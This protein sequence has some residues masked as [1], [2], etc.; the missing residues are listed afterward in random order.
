LTYELNESAAVRSNFSRDGA[1]AALVDLIATA[2]RE[3]VVRVALSALVGLACCTA[4]MSSS[5]GVKRTVDGSLFLTEMIGCGLIR[6]VDLMKERQFKDPDIASDL[7]ALHALLHRNYKEMTR[8]DVYKAEVESG[9]LEW[10]V[11][12]TEKFFKEHAKKMEGP[13]GDFDIVRVSVNGLIIWPSIYSA[14]D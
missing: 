2:P 9:H 13:D 14:C 10:G 4:D 12:H 3:K 6:H 11:V 1:V 5:D 8:F 7:D